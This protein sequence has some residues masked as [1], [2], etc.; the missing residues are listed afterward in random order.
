LRKQILFH[1]FIILT[2]AFVLGLVTGA[3]QGSGDVAMAKS[4][5]ISHVTGIMVSLIMAVVG[6][7]W[8]D[9]QLG[10]RASRVLYWM[11]VHANYVVMGILGVLVPALGAAPELAVPEAPPAVGGVKALLIAGI[12]IA[13]V[14]SFVMSI[15]VLVGL[16]GR[17]AD[18]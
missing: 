17:R 16:R 6:L 9:L 4:W 12:V 8:S 1:A 18:V 7:L 14:S 13:T 10:R 15:L 11:T 5:L 3:V 2:V